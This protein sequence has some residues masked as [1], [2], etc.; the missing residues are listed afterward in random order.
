MS[1]LDTQ[2]FFTRRRFLRW[3]QSLIAGIGAFPMLGGAPRAFG[4]VTTTTKEGDSE[5]DYYAKLGIKTIMNA[6]G[7]YT[8][9]T[10]SLMPAQVQRAVARAALHPVVLKEL[11]TKAGE[12]IAGSFAA[13]ERWSAAA[14]LRRSRWL[15]QLACRRPTTASLR[16]SRN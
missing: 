8:D 6:A 4:A 9:L 1:H 15:P 3:S 16:T 14:A 7:T 13:R 11:Q 12:Y 2:G 10:G 5:D